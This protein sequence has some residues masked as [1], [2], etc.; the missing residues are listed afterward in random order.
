MQSSPSSVVLEHR[1]WYPLRGVL[2]PA[3]LSLLQPNSVFLQ[4]V[5]RPWRLNDVVTALVAQGI[6]GLT[7]TDVYGIGFQGGVLHHQRCLSCA[8]YMP[9]TPAC[10]SR[11]SFAPLGLTAILD[12]ALG[13]IRYRFAVLVTHSDAYRGVE[14]PPIHTTVLAS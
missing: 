12:V 14:A 2:F 11:I 6:K 3:W 13:H 8:L 1:L 9:Q 5:L 10:C 7:V 4:A